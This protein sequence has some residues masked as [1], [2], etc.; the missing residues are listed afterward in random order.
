MSRRDQIRMTD[1]EMETFLAEARTLQVASINADGTPHLVPMWFARH[2]DDL[3]FWTYG[4]SQKIVNL[5]RDPRITVM[6]EAGT[7]YEELKG[8][9]I[10]GRAKLIDDLDEVLRFGES[11][12][13]R[14]WGPITDDAIR[15]GVRMMGSKR[16]LVVVEPDKVVSW[17]HAKLGGG[18]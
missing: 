13:E 2:G 8:V 12:Y 18:Y 11:I 16:V 9:S 15:E 4:K 14:Y 7:Q 1:D 17:D 6:A 3:A 5:R 10:T